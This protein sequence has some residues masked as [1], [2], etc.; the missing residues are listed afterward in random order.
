MVMVY[1]ARMIAQNCPLPQKMPLPSFAFK[2]CL[3][4]GWLYGFWILSHK[5]QSQAVHNVSLVAMTRMTSDDHGLATC[6]VNAV[7]NATDEVVN[8]PIKQ[9]I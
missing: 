1:M 4:A 7:L 2:I 8:T 3:G 6:I 9:H 5:C